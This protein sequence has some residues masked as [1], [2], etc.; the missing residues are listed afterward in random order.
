MSVNVG[1][2]II[3]TLYFTGYQNDCFVSVGFRN[4]H[5]PKTRFS[6]ECKTKMG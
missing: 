3:I 1:K 4:V 5:T 2:H 6:F